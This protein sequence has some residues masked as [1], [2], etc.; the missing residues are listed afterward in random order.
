MACAAQHSRGLEDTKRNAL[1]AP[2]PEEALAAAACPPWHVRTG[3]D[4]TTKSALWLFS[5][6]QQRG[7]L[8]AATAC[9]PPP[10]TSG[11]APRAPSHSDNARALI[12]HS[13]GR[14]R[15]CVAMP[16]RT[17][18]DA[19]ATS[20]AA[21]ASSG[22]IWRKRSLISTTPQA[23]A[24]CLPSQT[25]SPEPGTDPGPAIANQ[26]PCTAAGLGCCY[27]SSPKLKRRPC[28]RGTAMCTRHVHGLPL[29]ASNG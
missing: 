19:M 6:R 5:H 12:H 3:L 1:G 25:L 11:R 26:A 7:G 27:S 15:G 8:S 21:S 14:Q 9:P 17:R 13:P 16:T 23:P 24:M 18:D 22:T 10:S 4:G 29:R 20:T 2:L 28:P